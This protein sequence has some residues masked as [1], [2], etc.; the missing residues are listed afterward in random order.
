MKRALRRGLNESC[1]WRGFGEI[2]K[3]L[4]KS[5]KLSNVFDGC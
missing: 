3:S 1:E 5:Q 2:K 4:K